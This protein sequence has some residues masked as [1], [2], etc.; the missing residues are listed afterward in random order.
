[1]KV[2]IQNRSICRNF[3][4]S[5]TAR[6]DNI[7][8]WLTSWT[9]STVTSLHAWPLLLGQLWVWGRCVCL[10]V[11]RNM[12]KS[13]SRARYWDSIGWL[14]EVTSRQP[15][16]VQVPL[17]RDTD[18]SHGQYNNTLYDAG[19]RGGVVVKLLCYKPEG[20]GFETRWGKLI[21]SIHLNLP[22]ALGPGVYSASNRIEY[23]KQKDNVSW[24]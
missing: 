4:R 19:A 17:T 20:R 3:K 14:R 18:T 9:R 2:R 21:F 13:S 8:E 5:A 16:L 22:A 23:Q 10:A 24:E 11:C 6:C 1:M 7:R 15:L 12:S